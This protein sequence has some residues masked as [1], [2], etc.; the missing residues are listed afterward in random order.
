MLF[1]RERPPLVHRITSNTPSPR[2]SPSSVA[3][4][5]AL[6]R[7]HHSPSTEA[8]EALNVGLTARG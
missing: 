1:E 7:E 5:V 4:I 6:G 3:G 8:S 2:S